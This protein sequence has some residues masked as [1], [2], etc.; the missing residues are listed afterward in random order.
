MDFLRTQKHSIKA[1]LN[2]KIEGCLQL[3]AN[4]NRKQN[5]HRYSVDAGLLYALQQGR[6]VR[7][8]RQIN[9]AL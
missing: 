5:R 8:V 9:P 4:F 6:A 7:T 1:G 2:E 3:P